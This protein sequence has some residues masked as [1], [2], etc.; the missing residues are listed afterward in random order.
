[1]RLPSPARFLFR[2]IPKFIQR[3]GKMRRPQ[4]HISPQGKVETVDLLENNPIL[5]ESA[6]KTAPQL[7][8]AAAASPTKLLVTLA[9]DAQ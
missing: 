7:V 2:D 4:F 9:I 5:G 6:M 3:S 1:M 8:Y